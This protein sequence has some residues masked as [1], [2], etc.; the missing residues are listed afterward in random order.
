LWVNMVTSVALGLVISFEPHEADVMRRP[1]RAV[2]RPIVT[3]FGNPGGEAFLAAPE[4][5]TWG[6]MLVGL[7]ALGIVGRRKC[8]TSGAVSAA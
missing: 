1:P 6:L 5:S 3:G 7:G 2:D 4:P 8:R